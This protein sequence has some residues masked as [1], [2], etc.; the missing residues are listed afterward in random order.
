M[1]VWV[2]FA[3]ESYVCDRKIF[4][5][6]FFP[7]CLHSWLWLGV[8]VAVTVAAGASNLFHRLWIKCRIQ[9]R[10][11]R[12]SREL[13]QKKKLR[14]SSCIMCRYAYSSLFCLIL[15]FFFILSCF[16]Q[17]WILRYGS[18][19]SGI[20]FFF[21]IC[22]LTDPTDGILQCRKELAEYIHIEF[23][24]WR[25]GRVLELNNMIFNFNAR[26]TEDFELYKYKETQIKH[27]QCKK[28]D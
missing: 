19:S 11:K 22:E 25:R 21:L 17:V 23:I 7:C 4:L 8:V 1:C 14:A 27:I 2:S 6:S 10:K 26:K 9:K 15:I 3:L 18:L 5:I 24:E 16:L 13:C 28:C 12:T 20:S